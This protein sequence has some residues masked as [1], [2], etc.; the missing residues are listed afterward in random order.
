M[1]FVTDSLIKTVIKDNYNPN[2]IKIFQ[3][4]HNDLNLFKRPETYLTLLKNNYGNNSETTKLKR[5]FKQLRKQRL[6][7][8]E[9]IPSINGRLKIFFIFEKEYFIVIT[10]TKL[11][12]C[13]K[14]YPDGVNYI[15]KNSYFL[16]Y[17]SWIK[18]KEKIKI[19]KGEIIKCF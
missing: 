16:D 14:F 10:K 4:V 9:N 3:R 8:D 17:N 6:I 1:T 7:Y 19:K 18:A 15:L 11:Y 12:Y 13:T 2:I 5:K